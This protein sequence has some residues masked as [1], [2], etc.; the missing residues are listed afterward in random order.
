MSVVLVSVL[1]VVLLVFFSLCFGVSVFLVCVLVSVFFG[2]HFGVTVYRLQ[3]AVKH[4]GEWFEKR[5]C[6]LGYCDPPAKFLWQR[7]H[8]LSFNATG[9]DVLK[10]GQVNVAIQG[11]AMGSYESLSVHTL[12]NK[13]WQSKI[14]LVNTGIDSNLYS[15]F[16]IYSYK[17]VKWTCNVFML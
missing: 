1:L 6:S 9:H 4:F 3:F 14:E 8:A 16:F 7:G 13:S 17:L 2:L 11:Q 15:A 12:N 10:P 5:D